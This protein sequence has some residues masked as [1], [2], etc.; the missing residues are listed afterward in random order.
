MPKQASMASTALALAYIARVTF[1]AQHQAD[2][3][4]PPDTQARSS[5]SLHAG[6]APPSHAR[7]TGSSPPLPA[8]VPGLPASGIETPGD[9]SNSSPVKG[10]DCGC[11]GCLLPDRMAL[12]GR[13]EPS[14][15]MAW[16][17]WQQI[18]LVSWSD[19]VAEAA[20]YQRGRCAD[21]LMWRSD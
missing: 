20:R 5:P 2:S 3:L 12:L 18:T 13:S 14:A 6:L 17:P 15:P 8:R 1:H 11:E 16:A 9:S 21:C 7:G 19:S 10:A 4:L